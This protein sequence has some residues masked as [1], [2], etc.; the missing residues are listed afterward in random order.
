MM[1]RYASHHMRALGYGNP[2]LDVASQGYPLG[3]YAIRGRE[4]QLIDFFGGIGSPNIG[5]TINAIWQYNPN[6]PLY[7]S[8]SNAMFGPLK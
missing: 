1:N 6:R 2:T 3:Y 7:M 4:Q 5:N 8:A